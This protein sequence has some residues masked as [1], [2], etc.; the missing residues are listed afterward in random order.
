MVVELD[1]LLTEIEQDDRLAVVVFRNRRRPG[2]LPSP[3]SNITADS[4]PYGRAAGGAH[5]RSTTGANVA[6]QARQI[7]GGDDQRSAG[8]SS[9]CGQRV[10]PRHRYPISPVG[11]RGRAGGSSRSGSPSCPGGGPSTRL[12]GIVGRGAGVSRSCSVGEDLRRGTRRAVRIRPTAPVA[13][14]E[15]VGFVNAFAE[16]VLAFRP[17]RACRHQALRQRLRRFPPTTR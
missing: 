2:L 6:D 10:R 1:T 14:A 17:A 11:R 8:Q 3:I 4:A 9:R 5:P 15:F 13:D 7:A 16:R 12:P